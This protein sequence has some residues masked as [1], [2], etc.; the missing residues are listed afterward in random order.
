MTEPLTVEKL[1]DALA[2]W[3]IGHGYYSSGV[4]SDEAQD[5]AEAV[6]LL[7]REALDAERLAA[8][9]DTLRCHF[10]STIDWDATDDAALRDMSP[11]GVRAA[12]FCPV[13]GETVCH[14]CCPLAPIRNRQEPTD[15]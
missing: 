13:C 2:H 1:A 7:V 9:A 10:G 11:S 12:E 6:W 4:S 5:M 8:T 15:D 14:N 3:P